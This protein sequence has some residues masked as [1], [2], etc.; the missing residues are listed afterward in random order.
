[1]LGGVST[2]LYFL[3]VVIFLQDLV[4]FIC[5]SGFDNP[6]FIVRFFAII[7]V[8]EFIASVLRSVLRNINDVK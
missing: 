7:V 4:D 3:K 5:A 8:L 6:E 2:R 1:M